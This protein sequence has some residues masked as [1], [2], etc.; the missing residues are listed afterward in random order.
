MQEDIIHF[1]SEAVVRLHHENE[2]LQG[3]L[4]ML[5]SEVKQLRNEVD[6][7][8]KRLK[9]VSDW[10]DKLKQAIHHPFRTVF[11]RVF[12]RKSAV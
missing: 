10:Q 6:S 12:R 2:E 7:Q 8:N 5:R 1:I 4:H 11:R 9:K 3:Q